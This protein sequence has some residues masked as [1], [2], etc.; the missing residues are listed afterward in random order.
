MR[1]YIVT[2]DFYNLTFLLRWQIF[3]TFLMAACQIIPIRPE[4]GYKTYI[5]M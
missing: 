4:I 1:I 2:A 5:K 3:Y